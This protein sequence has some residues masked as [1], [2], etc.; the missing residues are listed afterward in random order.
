MNAN[1]YCTI[2]E[3]ERVI[4][5]EI[6]GLTFWVGFVKLIDQNTDRAE[7]IVYFINKNDALKLNIGDQISSLSV[8]YQPES[9]SRNTSFNR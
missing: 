8:F 2:L 7:G 1:Q 9:N 3:V 5:T 4:C 6:F